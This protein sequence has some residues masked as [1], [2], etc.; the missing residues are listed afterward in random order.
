MRRARALS[1]FAKN[2]SG[3]FTL[4]AA[5]SMSVLLLTIGFGINVAQSLNVK[6]SLQSA[7]DSAVT[8]TARDLT[9]GTIEEKDARRMVEAFLSAN[10]TSRFST[11]DRFVLDQLVVDRT[12]RTIS[13]TAH[14]NVVLAFP[15]FNIG[16][17]RVGTESA[18][19]YSDV[20]VEVAMMLDLT[21]SMKKAG[22]D[23]K[24]GDLQKAAT[25]AV[26]TLLS[27]QNLNDR[28]RVALVPYA[29]SVNVGAAIAEKAVYIEKNEADR[30]KVVSNADPR[31]VTSS[32]R[33]YCATE[34]KGTAYVYTDDGPD[35]AMV[36]RDFLLTAFAKGYTDGNINYLPSEKCPTVAVVPLTA[37]L[38]TLTDT[39]EKFV[40][41]GGTGG[42]IG[43][44][45]TWYMLSDKWKNVLATS[46]APGPYKKVAKYAILM[47]D[48]EFNLGFSGAATVQEAY[49]AGAAARS[50]PHATKLCA[51]MRKAGIEIFT[52]GFKLP[53]DAARKLMRDCATPDTG[54]I[55]HYYDTSSG[56]ELDQ[57]FQQITGNIEGL[58]L[59]K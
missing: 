44:Q 23:D 36:N 22:T 34:R 42:H 40:A 20:N 18:A 58:A 43:V 6:S 39:I 33:D 47:T 15:M 31:N 19:V 57:A 35:V 46:A 14:A 13:A 41:D 51:E 26:E 9:T 32:G 55:K 25:R 5:V 52:I 8:S 56:P 29:N 10:S 1:D 27:G 54:G 30:G 3:N 38:K 12:A 4:M 45:W 48:G 17:P 21:G 16:D 59:T 28:V 7:L 11:N 49:G 53:N 50:I 37:N 24:L 2:R